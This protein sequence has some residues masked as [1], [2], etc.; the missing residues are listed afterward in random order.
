MPVS[1]GFSPKNRLL[2]SL[3]GA[4]FDHLR[5]HLQRVTLRQKQ[6]LHEAGTAVEYVFFIEDGLASVVTTM[7]DGTGIEVLMIGQEGVIGV[8]YLL[9]AE[10]SPQQV[11]MQVPGSAWRVSAAAARAAFEQNGRLRHMVLRR[12]GA[13]LGMISQ[14]A[15]CNRLHSVEQ[16][17]ARWLLNASDRIASNTMPM[18]HEFLSFLPGVRRSGVTATAGELQRS[19][20]IRYRRGQLTIADRAGL[21]ACACECYQ[22]DRRQLDWQRSEPG[23]ASV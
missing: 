8:P 4:E 14:T 22:F 7:A 10:T 9:G 23:P 19:G 15:A 11:I 13:W 2:S 6:V 18:T 12:A 21:Q 20:L 3:P 1:I 16:R 5:P 17:R